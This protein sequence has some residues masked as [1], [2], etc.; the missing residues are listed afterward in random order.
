MSKIFVGLFE[1]MRDQ[2][3]N[4]AGLLPTGVLSVRVNWRFTKILLPNVKS[5]SNHTWNY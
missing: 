5:Q 1:P 2:Q 3:H 4:M